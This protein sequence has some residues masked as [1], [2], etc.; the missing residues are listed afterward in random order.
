MM[1]APSSGW[2]ER[3]NSVA[4]TRLTSSVWPTSGSDSRAGPRTALP[5]GSA[6]G[7]AG[8]SVR[9]SLSAN[10]QADRITN[11][12]LANSEGWNEWPPK[13]QPAARAVDLGPDE[14][15]GDHAAEGDERSSTSA[16]RRTPRGESSEIVSMMSNAERR[17]Q[18]VA[19]D[20]VVGRQALL[21]G[22]GGL[23]ASEKHEA[24]ADDGEDRA[25]AARG[26][27]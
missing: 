26:R 9:A 15:H 18:E 17:E 1:P 21:D 11:A 14:V 20:E 16:R 12:G 7:S 13:L 3:K 6:S 2:P 5:S 27:R 24:G 22:D 8:M 4:H 25:D 10:S 19:L 23:A